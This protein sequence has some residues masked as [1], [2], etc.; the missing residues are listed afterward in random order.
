MRFIPGGNPDVEV[1]V[2]KA[3]HGL[4]KMTNRFKITRGMDKGI[5]IDIIT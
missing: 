1:P 3:G 4:V 2:D 5:E